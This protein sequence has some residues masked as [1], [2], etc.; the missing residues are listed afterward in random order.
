MPAEARQYVEHGWKLVIIPRGLKSPRLKEWQLKENAITDPDIAEHIDDNVGLAHAWSGTCCV[1]VDDL[2]GSRK[3]LL[4]RGISLDALLEAPG[5]V[6]LLSGREN[7]AKLIYMLDKPLRSLSFK[8]FELRCATAKGTTV[9]DVLPPS[10][11]PDTG[12]P[13][14]WEY[15]DENSHWSKAP[16]LPA[17]LRKLWEDLLNTTPK[18][19]AV[20]SKPSKN[21]GKARELLYRRN[22]DCSYEEWVQAGMA[23]HHEASG[24]LDGLN[25]WDEWSARSTK[26]K[27]RADLE[28]HWQSFGNS[29]NPVTIASLRTDEAATEDEFETLPAIPEP[30]PPAPGTSAAIA[31]QQKEAIRKLIRNDA[32]R[33]M[34]LL[35][36]LQ[37]VLQIPSFVNMFLAYDEFKDMLM[38]APLDDPN[39]W[40]PFRD[41]DYTGL[42]IWL[43]QKGRFMPV[44]HDI[45]RDAIHY[46]AEANKMDTAQVWLKSLEWDGVPRIE[47]FF[48]T[49]MKTDDTPYHRS[50]GSYWWTAL[51]GRVMDPGC[52]A[53]MI[54]ILVGKQGV[55]KSTGIAAMVPDPEFFTEIHLEDKDDELSRKMRGLLIGELAEMRGLRTTAVERILAFVTRKHE[56][57][58]PK[59]REFT[60]TFARR[61]MLMGTSNDEELL[62]QEE[63]RRWLPMFVHKVDREAIARD[64]N[65]LWA[66]GRVRWEQNGIHWAKAE[67]LAKDEHVKFKAVDPWFH[68]VEPWLDKLPPNS[69]IKAHE[70]LADAVGLDT[71]LIKKADEIRCAAIMRSLGWDK[72]SCREGDRI[73]RFWYNTNDLTS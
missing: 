32:G 16:P 8:V 27:G 24:G 25:L 9:Q 30:P 57:W 49:Y 37:T 52:Q 4:A 45:V 61:C 55:G 73:I 18:L 7:R 34:T 60:T 11:H 58:V 63:N 66:E 33:I 42:R 69:R 12:Q 20:A 53:D 44:S 31:E 46:I 19:P 35:P 65:Q 38:F 6:K 14:Y 68:L 67:I 48:P 41:T 40:R 1:D 3:W 21:L 5:A 26:Y 22:P 17:S 59:Y 47:T 10:V 70:V 39:S 51:A 23:L 2:N 36:N 13:Y 28:A 43:E 15:N 71:R 62:Y 54:P 64:R 29:T 72:K 50:V 56:K